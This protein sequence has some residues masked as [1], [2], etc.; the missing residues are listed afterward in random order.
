MAKLV[1]FITIG[2]WIISLFLLIIVVSD[3]DPGNP[4]K[5]YRVIIGIGFFIISALT[6]YLYRRLKKQNAL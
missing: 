5:A 4:F 2:I 6:G 1:L 3:I